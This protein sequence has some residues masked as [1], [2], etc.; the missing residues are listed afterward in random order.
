MDL[1][2]VDGRLTIIEKAAKLLDEDLDDLIK[3]RR[4]KEKRLKKKQG[5]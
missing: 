3:K 4:L 5:L 2:D 1:D